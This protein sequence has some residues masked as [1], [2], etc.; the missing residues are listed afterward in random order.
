MCS[1]LSTKT[2]SGDV[3]CQLSG[4]EEAAG[5]AGGGKVP[6]VT[7]LRLGAYVLE[8]S[9][10]EQEGRHLAVELLSL[11]V[12]IVSLVNLDSTMPS[13]LTLAAYL[14][15]VLTHTITLFSQA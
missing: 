10:R 9:Q 4:G 14:D 13:F 15:D 5:S 11:H 8:F 6:K 7:G 1:P 2:G 12:E 3:E